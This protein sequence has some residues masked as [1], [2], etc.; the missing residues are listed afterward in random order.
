MFNRIFL[1]KTVLEISVVLNNEN[2]S[3]KLVIYT[4]SSLYHLNFQ[5]YNDIQNG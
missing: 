4:G 3:Y 5:S 2:K 1:V